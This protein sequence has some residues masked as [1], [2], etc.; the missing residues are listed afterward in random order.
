[1]HG[2]LSRHPSLRGL[3]WCAQIIQQSQGGTLGP[4]KRG[5][6]TSQGKIF[7]AGAPELVK[8]RGG[9]LCQ[10]CPDSAERLR[11]NSEAGV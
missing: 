4:L 1:M 2:L 8:E 10:V 3:V 6:H 11:D 9:S 7:F 5:H